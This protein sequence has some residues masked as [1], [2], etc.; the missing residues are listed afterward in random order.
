VSRASGRGSRFHTTINLIP[1]L[2]GFPERLRNR[3]LI[4]AAAFEFYADDSGSEPQ[5]KNFFLAG[6]LSTA[7]KW[8]AL[9]NEWDSALALPPAIDY[10]KM[11]EAAGF[12]DQFS[13]HRGWNESNRKDRL[14]TLARIIQKY[15][16]LRMSVSIRHDLF[17]KYVL[18]LPA[19]ERSLS[20]DEPYVLLCY[21]LINVVIMFA[22][23][24]GVREPIDFIFD[25][26]SA[27]N[28]VLG[29]WE[30]FKRTL[31]MSARGRQLSSLIG[32]KPFFLDEKDRLPLQAADLYVWQ[33]RNHYMDN[34]RFPNQKIIVPMN[35]TLKLFRQI[36]TDH[37]PMTEKILAEQHKQLVQVGERIKNR[38]PSINLFAAEADRKERRKVRR[39]TKRLKRKGS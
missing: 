24:H 6:F 10:F 4:M 33:A 39:K 2:S 21:R 35:P 13:Q 14:V 7:E 12:W 34:H 22:H 23:K 3:R 26:Q 37:W 19:L 5:G 32:E 28:E 31:Q 1:G 29:H 16:M 36:P 15:A 18:S 11:S 8:A 27:E 30:Q 20:T 25:H 38:D 9:S 17:E